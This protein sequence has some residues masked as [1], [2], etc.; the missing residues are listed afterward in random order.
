MAAEYTDTQALVQFVAANG[1]KSW[2]PLGT[3][4]TDGS[5]T[6]IG[7][8]NILLSRDDVKC[9]AAKSSAPE[10]PTPIGASGGAMTSAEKDKMQRL[11]EDQVS[12]V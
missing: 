12:P 5:K 7:A 3:S 8:F 11:C 1:I 10:E 6:G 4:L 9:E 2:Q